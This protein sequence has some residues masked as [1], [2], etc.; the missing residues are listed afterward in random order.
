MSISVTHSN[1]NGDL[2]F[3]L[4]LICVNRFFNIRMDILPKILS[5]SEIYGA[6]TDGLLKGTPIS[7][8]SNQ[9]FNCFM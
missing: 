2:S 9:N 4:I 3:C 5:S 6:L 7:G 1:L 8:V